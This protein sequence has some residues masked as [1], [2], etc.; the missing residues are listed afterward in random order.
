MTRQA[1]STST[2][3]NVKS[4]NYEHDRN[5]DRPGK[6]VVTLNGSPPKPRLYHRLLPM[7][8]KDEVVVHNND[9]STLVHALSE[10]VFYV[11]YD[12][13]VMSTGNSLHPGGRG[14]ENFGIP[15]L[16]APGVWKR[17][18]RKFVHKLVARIRKPTVVPVNEFHLFYDG[19]KAEAYKRA[20]EWLLMRSVNARKAQITPFVKAE[21]TMAKPSTGES[22][23]VDEAVQKSTCSNVPRVIQPR[24]I[25][26]GCA[27]G[28]H[29]KPMEGP[30]YSAINGVFKHEVVAKGLNADRRGA[31]IGKYWSLYIKP[32]CISYDMKR[33]DQHVSMAAMSECEHKLYNKISGDP[34][35]K[36]MLIMQ[37]VNHGVAR[38][39]D[40]TVEYTIGGNRMSGDMNTALGNVILLCAIVYSFLDSIGLLNGVSLVDDGDDFIFITE[41]SNRNLLAG[42]SRYCLDM[43]FEVE[44]EP[45]VFVIEEISFC[46]ARPI[47]VGGTYRMVREIKSSVVKDCTSVQPVNNEADWNYF[48][49][50]TAECGNA[51]AGDLPVLGAYYTAMGRGAVFKPRYQRQITGME[52][53]AKG[54]GQKCWCEP[55]PETRMSFYRAFGVSPNKQTALEDLFNEFTPEYERRFENDFDRLM[56]W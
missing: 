15:P 31:L 3:I 14:H 42:F 5:P 38:L 32:M 44:E 28:C 54:M 53:L 23:D 49:G 43:G 17:R 35:L 41:K 19:R 37:L 29:V 27:L 47:Y 22:Y 16:P 33:F 7:G 9:V 52:Q 25:V 1:E 45:P 10:R 12:A 2:A 46:Q 20:G 55:A 40:G 21:K 24:D 36:R 56:V 11:K 48:R 18:T 13:P 50:A 39:R 4:I 6:L 8:G 51:L 26:Y 30:I 34:E